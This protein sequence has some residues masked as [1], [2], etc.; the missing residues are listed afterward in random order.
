M[1]VEMFAV[2]RLICSLCATFLV[3]VENVSCVAFIAM[4]TRAVDIAILSVRPSVTFRYC[5]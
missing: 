2:F 1:F 3:L 5:I 4:L